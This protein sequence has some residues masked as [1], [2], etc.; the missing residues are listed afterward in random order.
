M[1]ERGDALTD[2]T[3]QNVLL[4]LRPF[5]PAVQVA[6]VDEATGIEVSFQAPRQTA[7]DSL[8]RLAKQ[9]LRY[10][11]ERNKAV[12]GSKGATL[13]KPSA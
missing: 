10:V 9:K 1:R 11:I 7:M 5:G 2:Q 3:A 13:L 12:A 4:E 6:A 8:Q